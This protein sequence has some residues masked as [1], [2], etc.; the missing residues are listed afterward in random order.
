MK[1]LLSSIIILICTL[2]HASYVYA[3]YYNVDDLLKR[4]L[5]ENY[6]GAHKGQC[7]GYFTG[8]IDYHELL[9]GSEI[10]TKWCVSTDEISLGT[11][12]PKVTVLM[13]TLQEKAPE[14][15]KLPAIYTVT[16]ILG[17]IYPCE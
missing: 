10:N 16:D 11:M 3:E 5:S 8:I 12:V 1:Y 4:C 17:K 2:S 14:I 13:K 6:Q 7:Y 9:A 15:L